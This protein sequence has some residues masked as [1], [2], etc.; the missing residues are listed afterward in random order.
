MIEQDCRFH[1]VTAKG[2][3]YDAAISDH[4]GNSRNYKITIPYGTQLSLQ[5][6]TANHVVDDDTGNAPA[7][8]GKGVLVPPGQGAKPISFTVTGK[9]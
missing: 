8:S 7:G 6:P 1:I 5:V 9:P 3:H 2:H 4:N